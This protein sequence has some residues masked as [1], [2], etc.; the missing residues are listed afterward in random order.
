M[1]YVLLPLFRLYTRVKEEDLDWDTRWERITR[2]IKK[3]SP[4]VLC[5]Q[6]VQGTTDNSELSVTDTTENVVFSA[7]L[8]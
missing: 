4:D 1:C 8:K 5:L 2:E 3:Y 6:E 7:V